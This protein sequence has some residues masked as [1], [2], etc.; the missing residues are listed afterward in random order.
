MPVYVY[1]CPE[2]LHSFEKF[3]P[4]AQFQRTEDCPVCKSVSRQ[5]ITAPIVIIPAHMSATGNS[6]YHSPIDG[7]PITNQ[8]QRREDLARSGCIEYEPG[9][10][11]DTD[12]RVIEGEKA[13]DKAV[14]ET[15]DREIEK[16]PA[17]KRERLETEMMAGV[18][19][20]TVRV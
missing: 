2:C 3:R 15:F 12:R 8:Y 19:A 20:E 11:Q 9:M 1:A 18:T 5:V 16:M 7:R 14:D 4:V 6:S 17:I 13:L 10:K